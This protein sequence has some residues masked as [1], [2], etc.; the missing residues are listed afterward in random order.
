MR[1]VFQ[2]GVF[3]CALL[4]ALPARAQSTAPSPRSFYEEE[5]L[6][7]A[8]AKT[9]A[10]PDLEPD[11][12]ILEGIDVVALDVI[13]DRD[14]APEALNMF[15]VT[16]REGVVR[17]EVLLKIGEPY[18][19][20]LVDDTVRALRTFRQ[21]SLVIVQPTRGSTPD[22]VR[23]LV[24]TKDVWSLRANSDFG[25]SG[26]GIDHLRFEPT[27]RNVGGTFDSVFG[28]FEL[29]PA[30]M[31]FG[32]GV[33]V[34]RL[35]A[36]PLYMSAEANVVMNRRRG[37]PEGTYGT[38]IIRRPVLSTRQL[39]SWVVRTEWHS[40]IIRR[41]L[42]AEV[43]GFD[44]PSTP[45]V[46]RYPDQYRARTFIENMQFTRSFGLARKVDLTLGAEVNAKQYQ[47]FDP[48]RVGAIVAADHRRLREPT[49]DT[50]AAPFVETHVYESRF[51]RTHDL[52]T[53]GLAEDYRL[54]YDVTARA[55]PVTRFVGSSRNFVGFDAVAQ[56]VW[57]LGDGMSRLNA[58][59]ILEAQPDNIPVR[60]HAVNASI[61]S[62]R[63]FL[64]RLV[65]DGLMIARP[66]NYLNL[67]STVGGESRLRGQP[68]G[69]L[70]GE[71][72]VAVNT[73][74]RSR[75][76]S[77]LASQ[78]GGVL[79]YDVADA[80][81]DWPPKPKS[82]AGFGLRFVFPQ[83][84]RN[85]IRFDVGFPIEKAPGAGVVGFYFAVEQAFPAR[86][87]DLPTSVIQTMQSTGALGQ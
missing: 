48:R 26:K 23:L 43:A 76:V 40:E 67:R 41:Y 46:E 66:R 63:F 75:P 54:G 27:E 53:L 70:I 78:I 49:S 71:N 82:S 39:W 45:E 85:V 10:V 29:Y 55:Y 14:P 84:D 31:T 11:G 5:S 6:A 80:S 60:T 22:R 21:V 36:R 35:D 74:L 25:I 79:F 17:R 12:K 68:S 62:P 2:R 64:G 38:A 51:L 13:E 72:L 34:P 86:T 57:K 9:H 77:I 16:T 42:N 87:P 33:Y 61:Y 7:R 83:L 19:Q 37:E 81:D 69:A 58:E 18:K 3:A 28:R 44:A 32:A 15:H 8:L 59:T 4:A 56:Y 73:E 65:V 52:D 24:V 20:F 50:R 1:R 30:T 47:G